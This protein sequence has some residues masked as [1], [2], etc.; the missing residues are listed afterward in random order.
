MK[1]SCSKEKTYSYCYVAYVDILGFKNRVEESAKGP[2][3]SEKFNEIIELLKYVSQINSR[4]GISKK[5]AYFLSDSIFLVFPIKG[6]E[7]ASVLWEIADMQAKIIELG[8]L[9]RGALSIG[10]VY[11]DENNLFGPVVNEVTSLEK[12]IN[13]PYIVL[14]NM[15]FENYILN[16]EDSS[17]NCSSMKSE[18]KDVKEYLKGN[19]F[20]RWIAH[21]N[22]QHLSI[23]REV[24]DEKLKKMI[25]EGLENKCEKIRQKYLWLNENVDWIANDDKED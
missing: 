11:Y 21:I 5:E 6:N 23:E 14:S 24:I 25:D 4:K 19:L 8:F 16:I 20:F 12:E 18:I 10:E 15:F 2:N 9:V 3:K 17:F 13:N 1:K 22:K 7:I